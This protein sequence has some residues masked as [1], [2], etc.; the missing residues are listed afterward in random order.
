MKIPPRRSEQLSRHGATMYKGRARVVEQNYIGMFP[1]KGEE[2]LLRLRKEISLD[3]EKADGGLKIKS[4][5][6]ILSLLV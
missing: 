5:L 1:C 6:A 4:T 3:P 2:T